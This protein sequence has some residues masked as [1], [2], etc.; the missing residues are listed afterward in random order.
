MKT[1]SSCTLICAYRFNCFGL[2]APA[3]RTAGCV[4]KRYFKKILHNNNNESGTNGPTR[5][6]ERD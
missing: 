5:L 1:S 6:D 2:F 4:K 3:K